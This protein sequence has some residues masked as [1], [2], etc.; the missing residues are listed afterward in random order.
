MRSPKNKKK[1]GRRSADAA[2]T[3]RLDLS[4]FDVSVVIVNFLVDLAYAAVDPRLRLAG[5]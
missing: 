1:T 5:R 2:A 4:S 3:P